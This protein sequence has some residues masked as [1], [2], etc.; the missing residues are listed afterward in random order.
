MTVAELIRELQKFP[1]DTLVVQREHDARHI[2][3]RAMD[4]WWPR[5]V[6]IV[7]AESA[8]YAGRYYE[9]PRHAADTIDALEI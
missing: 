8:L 9:P 6:T 2:T 1:A 3:W 5:M 7:P 4:G